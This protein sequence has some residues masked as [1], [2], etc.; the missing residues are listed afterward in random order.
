MRLMSVCAAVALCAGGALGA[1]YFWTVQMDG[2]QEPDGGD[3]DG[4]GTAVF[5][6]NDDDPN[7]PFIDWEF[8]AFD[9]GMPLTAAHIHDGDFG[10][11]G[12]PVVDFSGQMS[13][14]GL[15]DLDLLAV[16][17][18]PEGFYINLHNADFPGGAIRGQIPAPGAGLVLALGLLA[19]RRRR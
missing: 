8:T 13:G 5:R 15:V 14:S 7:A 3:P 17:A 1:D 16:I 19:G 4:F 9:I 18:D 6:V 2:L 10:V 12:P 11:N